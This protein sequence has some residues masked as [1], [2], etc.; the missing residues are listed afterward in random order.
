MS[1]S[2]NTNYGALVALQNLNQTT[3]SL[4][5]VQARLNTGQKVA[6]A[7]D[8]GAV[9]A[10][11]ETQRTRTDA[12][13]AV[14]DG[15]DRAQSAIDT[16]VAAGEA[17]NT[18]LR[19]MRDKA[20]Q[21][22]A[23]GLSNDDRAKLQ[24]D[25]NALRAQIDQV[26]NSA[27]Y[28]GI[29]LVNGTNT[30]GNRL[31]VLTTDSANGA[32]SANGGQFVRGAASGAPGSTTVGIFDENTV[33]TGADVFGNVAANQAGFANGDTLNFR[34]DNGD[35]NIRVTIE[36]GDTVGAVIDKINSA[37][38]GRLTASFDARTG[39]IVYDSNAAF[40]IEATDAAGTGAAGADATVRAIFGAGGQGA[41]AGSVAYVAGG[42]YQLN[43]SPPGGANPTE[44]PGLGAA[45]STIGAVAAGDNVTFTMF[46]ANNAS[47][48]GDDRTFRVNITGDM[49]VGQYLDA[50]SAATNGSVQALYNQE[51]G[52]ITYQSN[53]AFQVQVLDQDQTTANAVQAINDF[54]GAPGANSTATT[55]ALAPNGSGGNSS[56]GSIV[57]AGADFRLGRGALSQVTTSL[58]ISTVAG[59][60]TAVSA[61]DNALGNVRTQLATFGSQATALTAQKDF[62]QK[63]GDTLEKSIGQLV[64]ADLARESARL[65][66][67]QIKQQLGTQALSIA[68]QAPSLVLSLF[69]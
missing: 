62:L 12:L 45:L 39:S 58:N 21:A 14:R 59:A 18:L 20:V 65:Q 61:I 44:V 29:N 28:N 8:N 7:R 34:F 26:A 52:V 27:V 42:G 51:T 63:L 66:S 30:G 3:R 9:W 54:L 4:E 37:V 68:N 6:N 25:F 17:I 24:T 33:I 43:G 67:L 48:G 38:G 1:T 22:Q 35:T 5:Q 16:G 13:S 36:T 55:A 47:G 11:A 2:V 57:V 49:T 53:E 60:G 50:V 31:N 19:N 10:I 23:A 69:R 56:S 46:G 15:I 41:A 64:D 40:S 32:G